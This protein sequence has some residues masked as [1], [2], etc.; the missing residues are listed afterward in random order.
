[1]KKYITICCMAA[2]LTL[3]G[4]SDW[5]DVKQIGQ[6]LEE[7]QF[8]TESGIYGVVNGFYMTMASEN[9]YGGKLTMTDLE[10]LAR[11]YYAPIDLTNLEGF[12]RFFELQCYAYES[13]VI[14]PRFA[15]IWKESYALI[16]QINKF[17]FNVEEGMIL[18]EADR[19]IVLGEAYALR[20]FLHFDLFRLFGPVPSQGMDEE[21][22]AY[23]TSHIMQVHPYIKGTVFIENVMTDI[24]KAQTLLANDPILEN[25][26]VRFESATNLSTTQKFN[27]CMRNRRMNILAVDALEARVQ[28]YIGNKIAAATL[29]SAA[30]QKMDGIIQW[31]DE[32]KVATNHNY[33][34]YSEML[35]AIENP[36]LYSRWIDYTANADYSKTH[37]VHAQHL[38][39]NIFGTEDDDLLRLNDLRAKSWVVNS[40]LG[41]GYYVSRKFSFLTF[42][43]TAKEQEL[44]SLIRYAQPLMRM[45]ELYYILAE[46]YID[47]GLL[48][49]A[50]NLF[51]EISAKRGKKEQDELPLTATKEELTDYL[52]RECYREFYGEGQMFYYLK[53]LA[54]TELFP[55]TGGIGRLYMMDLKNYVVPLPLDE[56]NG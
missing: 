45:T 7:E 49:D 22:I 25:G 31:S 43:E 21:S 29:A 32:T 35:F 23:N 53:R 40:D 46:T 37:A 18:S 13:T 4:C 44:T 39:R 54:K 33:I 12:R 34:F 38:V 17:I 27:T 20:A 1:M 3:S 52:E 14:E 26:V 24:A 10:H 19:N 47:N 15:Y 42:G 28:F 30:I 11:Y 50:I 36:N 16:L 2:L 8:T 51:N 5:L 6:N 55:T 56:K 48:E 41:S 9:L